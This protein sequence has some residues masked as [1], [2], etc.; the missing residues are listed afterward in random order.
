[1]AEKLVN[2]DVQVAGE[3]PLDEPETETDISQR[4]ADYFGQGREEVEILVGAR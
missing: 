1:V 2:A 3:I 4:V